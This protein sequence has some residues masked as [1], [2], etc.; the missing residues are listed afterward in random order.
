MITR[1]LARR[2]ERLEADLVPPDHGVTEHTIAFV[3]AQTEPK[4]NQWYSVTALPAA[5]GWRGDRRSRLE[6]PTD[7][8]H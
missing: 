7:N 5:G 2:L 8:E 6:M 4:P 3:D 1:T